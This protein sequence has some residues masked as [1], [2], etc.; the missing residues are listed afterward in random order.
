MQKKSKNRPLRIVHLTAS[1]KVG[2]AETLLVNLVDDLRSYQFEQSVIC[3]HDGFNADAIKE[4][5]VSVYN[6]KGFLFRYDLLFFIRLF[7]LLRKLSPD[8]IHSL[9]WVA[10]FAGR[11]I[12]HMLKIPIVCALHNN[13]GI[14]GKIRVLLDRCITKKT[15]LFIAVSDEVKS[16]AAKYVPV[17]N[18]TAVKVITNGIDTGR[19]HRLA[20]RLRKN[21]ADLNLSKDHF[22]I[23]SVGRLVE[24]K[25][26]SLFVDQIKDIILRFSHVRFVLVG[27]GPQ[28]QFLRQK[29]KEI[30]LQDYAVIVS[31]QVA[32]PYYLLFDCFVLP[33]YKEG[34]SIALLEAMSF[35]LPCIVGNHGR[36][37]PVIKSG[38]NG[39]VVTP[40]DNFGEALIPLIENEDIRITLSLA[41][42]KTLHSH[43]YFNNMVKSYA[44][45]FGS[46]S[47][48]I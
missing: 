47:N 48:R 42:K 39:I 24:L 20:M 15:D 17:I 29:I 37:H 46:V 3:F 2:G 34:I 25:N 30:G 14:N 45:L 11:L 21:R 5:G 1:L 9:L 40:N 33:S 26:Y 36:E 23:G 38:E 13:S 41:A 6:V 19:C 31:N 35:G 22:V 4:L 27:T 8:C 12:A 16:S 28:E 32:M 7:L 10:N 18:D 43:F 44:E